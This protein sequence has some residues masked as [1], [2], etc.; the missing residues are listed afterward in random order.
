MKR[1]TLCE[2]SAKPRRGIPFVK[3]D[4][5]IQPGPGRPPLTPAER[6]ARTL[7]RQAQERVISDIAAELRQYAQIA[8]GTIVRLAEHGTEEGTR[9]A[10]SRELLDRAFGK[11]AQA[12]DMRATVS[13]VDVLDADTIR[14]AALRLAGATAVDMESPT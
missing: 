4:R 9:L 6:E 7:R 8:V 13:S 5:R 14:R 1:A 10:A 2:E 3:G 11:A 12:I